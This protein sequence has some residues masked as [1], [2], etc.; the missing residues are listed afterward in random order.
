MILVIEPKS[1][2]SIRND[3]KEGTPLNQNSI[4]IDIKES[5]IMIS[6]HFF[7]EDHEFDR[8][9]SISLWVW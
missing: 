5:K 2:Q 9:K 8:D 1:K 6:M 4:L 7:P 3:S